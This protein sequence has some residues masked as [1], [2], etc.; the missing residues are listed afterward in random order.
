[1]AEFNEFKNKFI[2]LL[3]KIDKIEAQI[4]I[5]YQEKSKLYQEVNDV[6]MFFCPNE[7]KE[8]ITK[9]KEIKNGG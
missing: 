1:M 9:H 3:S 2:E 6:F 7:I 5:L 4:T 8:L